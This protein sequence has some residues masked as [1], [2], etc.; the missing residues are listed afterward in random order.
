VIDA[1]TLERMSED[2]LAAWVLARLRGQ[3]A[4]PPLS[5][6]HLET[7]FDFVRVIHDQAGEAFRERLERAVLA[8]LRQAGQGDLREGSDA[9]AVRLAALL[10]DGLDLRTAVPALQVVAARGAW[11]GHDEIAPDVEVAILV[12]LAGLQPERELWDHWRQLWRSG[13]ERLLPVAV[14]GMRR[15]NPQAALLFLPDIVRRADAIPAFPLGQLLWAFGR[16]PRYEARQIADELTSELSPSERE[17]CRAAL[18]EVGAE[19]GEIDAWVPPP[20]APP[21]WARN[22]L[23][24]NLRTP[25][26]LQPAEARA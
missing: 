17:R 22:P 11:G 20:K 14:T 1:A 6:A 24:D 12:A 21:A 25:Q 7:P 26:R 18:R 2:E 8:A 9:Q 4:D 15:S 23:V 3:Q 5:A 13:P 19:D 16:D 10:V